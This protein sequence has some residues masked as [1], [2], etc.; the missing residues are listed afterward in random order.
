M[1]LDHT[2]VFHSVNSQLKPQEATSTIGGHFHK[3]RFE[4]G[5]DGTPRV[6]ECGPPM[7]YKY[8]TRAG[9][10]QKRVCV[11]VGWEDQTGDSD[12]KVL[13]SHTH[14]FEY[15]HSEELLEVRAGAR[16]PVL[17]APV[18]DTAGS[19]GFED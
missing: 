8:V 15:L 19:V 4:I 3:V 13:D 5:A 14:T 11:Q 18:V 12:S 10:V 7:T 2:H 17:S 16:A 1:R 9:G 6:V